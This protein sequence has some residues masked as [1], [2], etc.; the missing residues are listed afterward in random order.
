MKLGDNNCTWMG[1]IQIKKSI[2]MGNKK[3][4]KINCLKHDLIN[5]FLKMNLDCL[6]KIS[7]FWQSCYF[8]DYTQV[9]QVS[10]DLA[11]AFAKCPG[12]KEKAKKRIEI[13]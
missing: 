10:K 6:N 9:Q 4:I 13:F 12:L 3:K 11:T 8:G 1:D 7:S 2:T 5:I